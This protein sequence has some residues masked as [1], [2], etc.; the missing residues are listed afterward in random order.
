[1][2]APLSSIC[3]CVGARDGEII[4]ANRVSICAGVQFF[5]IDTS[6]KLCGWAG[7]RELRCYRDHHQ[8]DGHTRRRVTHAL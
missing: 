4:A 6:S 1:M 7:V 8:E 3:V 5:A 2:A